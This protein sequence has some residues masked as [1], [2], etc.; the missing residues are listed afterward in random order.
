VCAEVGIIVESN[1]SET[2]PGHSPVEHLGDGFG[3]ERT[4]RQVGEDEVVMVGPAGPTSSRQS[5]W[6]LRWVRRTF[7]VTGSRSMDRR[8]WSVFVRSEKTSPPFEAPGERTTLTCCRTSIRPA[9]KSTS[10]QRSPHT[11]P[12]RMP[13]MAA[14]RNSGPTD[15]SAVAEKKARS[16]VGVHQEASGGLVDFAEGAEA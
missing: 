15:S 2:K 10:H 13:V 4:A 1:T 12:L 8:P 3:V 14:T 16:S 9:S 6:R 5:A 7:T 11:S